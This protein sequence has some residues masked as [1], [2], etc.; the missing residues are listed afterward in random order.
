MTEEILNQFALNNPGNNEYI[1]TPFGSGL[2]NR[3]W[4]VQVKGAEDAYILQ[5]INS[6]IFKNPA[7]IAFA[8]FFIEMLEAGSLNFCNFA[9]YL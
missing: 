7:D 4:K 2:I 5:N 3:T 9:P 6:A 8:G 1:F